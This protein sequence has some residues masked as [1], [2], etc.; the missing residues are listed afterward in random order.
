MRVPVG[1]R[2]GEGPPVCWASRKRLLQGIDL[3]LIG[4]RAR[5]VM[6]GLAMLGKLAPQR[7]C[8]RIPP[9]RAEPLMGNM[10]LTR[11]PAAPA[12]QGGGAGTRGATDHAT[13]PARPP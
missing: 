6:R 7:C 4:L 5:V 9:M 3:V 13:V 11:E 10:G 1:G 12:T 2:G 8:R